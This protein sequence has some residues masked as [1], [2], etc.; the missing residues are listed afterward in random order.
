MKGIDRAM[1]RQ[2]INGFLAE[3]LNKKLEPEQKELEK[4][5]VANDEEKITAI[6]DKIEKI[7]QKYRFDNW[8]DNAANRMAPQL[9]FGTHISKGVHPDSKGDN[10]NFTG[11]TNLLDGFVGSQ[12]LTALNLDASGNAAALPLFAF[13]NINIP[14][15]EPREI[16]LRDLIQADHPELSGIF[17]S[18]PVKSDEYQALF[19]KAL[20]NPLTSPATC[21]CNK[22]LLWPTDEVV[23][24]YTCLVPLFPSA[25][26]HALYN[27]IKEALYS[28]ENKLAR[29]NKK[30]KTAQ[31]KD[32]VSISDLAVTILGGSKPQNVSKLTSENG[33]RN[34]LLPSLPPQISR[35]TKFSISKRQRTIFN[36]SLRY[37]C[38]SGLQELYSVIESPRN[39]V[40]VREQRKEA[41]DMILSQI[42]VIATSIQKLN[43]AGWSKDY[44]LDMA[45]KCWL[46]PERADLKD[47]A[48]FAEQRASGDWVN[49]I[50]RGFSL[51]LNHILKEKFKKQHYDFNDAE[52]LEWL[53]AMRAA[54]KASQR[55]GE[56]VFA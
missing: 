3:L 9:K 35:Q 17:A 52:H 31:Q 38:Y 51:W 30:K 34:Y 23:D 6:R 54:I 42:L 29:D 49:Q 2:A 25:L 39:T 45:E 56:G 48:A 16:R 32:Y 36:N 4:A 5:E 21:E 7:Q 24:N 19:K 47:E 50:E 14:V 27:R 43:Q 26:T 22:Q 20:S 1:V 15:D 8:L 53:K 44:E 41:L 33:G 12:T 40:D 11:A 28:A 18:D 13:F 55:A 10:I 46:D 37:H